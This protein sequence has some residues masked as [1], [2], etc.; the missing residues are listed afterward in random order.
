MSILVSTMGPVQNMTGSSMNSSNDSRP[1]LDLDPDSREVLEFDQLLGLISTYARTRGGAAAVLSIPV[2]AAPGPIEAAHDLIR[3]AM[4][5]LERRGKLLSGFL[6]DPAPGLARLQVPG[7]R[8]ETGELRDLALVVEAGGVTGAGLASL[9]ERDYPELR[10]TGA[11]LPDLRLEV[12]PIL[13]CIGPD[14]ALADDASRELRRIRQALAGNG[15]KLRR[16]LERFL[17]R[18]DTGAVIQDEFVTQRNGR[19]VLPIRADAER[20]VQGIVHAASSSGATL[21][22]EPLETVELNNEQ[23]RLAEEEAEEQDRI[24]AAWSGDLRLRIGELTEVVEW[25]GA[26]DGLQ[27]RAEYG[28]ES[29]GV[30]PTVRK[31]SP[32]LLHN[33]RHPLLDGRLREAGKRCVPISFTLDPSDQVLVISGPN[34]GGKTVAIKTLG[35]AT[36]MAQAAI[37]VTADR[38]V[39]PL[40]SQV[41]ADIGDHQSIEADLSTFSSHLVAVARFLSERKPPALLLFD[42]IGTGTEPSEG[43]ALAEAVL[44]ELLSPGITSVATTHF[45]RLKAWAYTTP[46]AASAAMEFD[47]ETLKPTFRVAMDAAGVSAGIE[48]AGRL[49]LPAAV[50]ERA[51]SLLGDNSRRTEEF[52]SRLRTLTAETEAGRDDLQKARERVA[53][54]REEQRRQVEAEMERLRRRSAKA[55]DDALKKFHEEARVEIEAIRDRKRRDR[56]LNSRARAE[57]RLRRLTPEPAGTARTD[58]GVPLD[59]SEL[60][61]GMDVLVRSLGRRGRIVQIRGRKVE[62]RLGKVGFTVQ[63]DDLA[64][65]DAAVDTVENRPRRSFIHEEAARRRAPEPEDTGRT[66]PARELMLLGKTVEEAL[67]A[68]DRFLD[69]SVLDQAAEVR[70]IHGHGTGRLKAAVRK[71]LNGHTHVASHRPG[72]AGEGGDGATVVSLMI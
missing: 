58:A 11:G 22:V 39:L 30:I 15:R 51:R 38:A 46:G 44:Q 40:Y 34:T 18:P 33:L 66:D 17:H 13:Q 65:P 50:V 12:R 26:L 41:R 25:I 43:A 53:R 3:E 19:Y 49:G 42:E 47:E 55:L 54:E 16:M 67:E 57:G 59:R 70:I 61:P 10:R 24:L 7:E 1:I 72:G 9:P 71:F 2:F 14:G 64:R 20:R 5:H 68:V 56:E 52:L 23:V 63:D 62:V 8:L 6:P 45:G 4:S 28:R 27:A 60:K 69:R 36:L 29:G 48:I 37:P 35:L 31:G 21:F 32:L